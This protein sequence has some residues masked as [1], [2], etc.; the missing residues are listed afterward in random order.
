MVT[1]SAHLLNDLVEDTVGNKL[2]EAVAAKVLG[3]VE[4]AEVEVAIGSGSLQGVVLLSYLRSD[5]SGSSQ[6][7][8]RLTQGRQYLRYIRLI[9]HIYELN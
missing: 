7:D 8:T 6:G 4:V 9:R 2:E 5:P 1:P 3:E